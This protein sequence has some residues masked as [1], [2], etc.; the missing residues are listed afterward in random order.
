[1][2]ALSAILPSLYV[3]SGKNDKAQALYQSLLAANHND[4]ELRDQLGKPIAS[5]ELCRCPTAIPIG[6]KLDPKFGEAYGDLAFAADEN[7][8]YELAIRALDERAKFLPRSQSHSLCGPAPMTIYGITKG[9]ENYHQFLKVANGKY[10]DQEWQA[11]HRL[12]A[13]EPKK[14]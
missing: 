10:P 9:S 3:K 5:E 4:P 2:L 13:I 14:K 7:K 1:M 11:T 12:I 8:N 6:G